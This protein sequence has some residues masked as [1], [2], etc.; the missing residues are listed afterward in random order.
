ML[1]SKGMDVFAH[2][3]KFYFLDASILVKLVI[4]EPGSDKARELLGNGRCQTTQYCLYEA[5][6]VIK[7]EWRKK[8][9]DDKKYFLAFSILRSYVRDDHIRVVEN[10]LEDFDDLKEAKK[11][12]D[13]YPRKIDLSDAL[14]IVSMKKGFYSLLHGE[15]QPVLV[16]SD[17]NLGKVAE[18]L[19]LKV[20]I[21]QGVR[22]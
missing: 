11:L 18:D 13:D 6:G 3:I 22:Q 5:Y 1:I 14:Q 8:R 15:S 4:D 21:I 19:D 10:S 16:T 2:T 17:E 20:T 7:R 9:I 12:V